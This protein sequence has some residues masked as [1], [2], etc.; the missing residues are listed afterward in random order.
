MYINV[1]ALKFNATIANQHLSTKTM[2]DQTWKVDHYKQAGQLNRPQNASV[3]SSNANN[4]KLSMAVND[5]VVKVDQRKALM[6]DHH[7][8]ADQQKKTPALGDVADVESEKLEKATNDHSEHIQQQ[9]E[10]KTQ[11]TELDEN[12]KDA[13]VKQEINGVNDSQSAAEDKPQIEQ[14][15]VPAG[16]NAN[17]HRK[18]SGFD[19]DFD[20]NDLNLTKKGNC[21]WHKW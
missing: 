14:K 5:P 9:K 10:R 13:R 16:Q 2:V 20:W 4:D 15:E 19:M 7:E 11:N 6:T 12:A 21:G 18:K 3:S 8:G 17:I 1:R